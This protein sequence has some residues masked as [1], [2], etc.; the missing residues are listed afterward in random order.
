MA[1]S[2]FDEFKSFLSKTMAALGVS[3]EF[4]PHEEFWLSL[5][6][7]EFTQGNV[8]G[9]SRA[10]RIVIPG[11]SAE[12]PF[13]QALKGEGLFTGTPFRRMPAGG[14]FMTGDQ[15]DEIAAWID[16]GC[17]DGAPVVS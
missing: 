2:N 6:Y 8:P 1:I 16:A 4:A 3:A 5:N 7:S 11:K 13:I 14:P 15:I 9:I 17:P 10:V 12:S